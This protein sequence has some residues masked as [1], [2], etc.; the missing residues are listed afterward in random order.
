MPKLTAQ[1]L[2]DSIIGVDIPIP[3][4]SITPNKKFEPFRIEESPS[5]AFAD[6]SS[7]I[8]WEKYGHRPELKR[9]YSF[10]R[11]R[12]KELIQEKGRET[13]MASVN[14]PSN[15]TR[16]EGAVYLVG[17]DPS[18][19]FA[20]HPGAIATV[21]ADLSFLYEDQEVVGYRLLN[22]EEKEIAA[23]YNIGDLNE[24]EADFTVAEVRNWNFEYHQSSV[25]T[26]T[27]RK[28]WV[29]TLIY[30]DLSIYGNQVATA[31]RYSPAGDLIARYQEY[32][33]KGTV[34]DFS[35]SNLTPLP[36]IIDY[37]YSRSIFDGAGDNPGL[38][39]QPRQP[40]GERSRTRLRSGRP[41]S[42]ALGAR[43]RH[44]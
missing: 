43:S 4:Q 41:R 3:P 12:I 18:G 25:K 33:Q 15:I 5:P 6:I 28:Q 13:A 37:L 19:E 21:Q 17:D 27:K 22:L 31:M 32:G 16:V 10:V 29:E 40:M 36:G 14:D 1:I 7:V 11:D 30:R 34:E 23:R 44:K 38:S 35:L 39:S 8:N 42:A 20:T 2:G 26:R 24:H 9:D